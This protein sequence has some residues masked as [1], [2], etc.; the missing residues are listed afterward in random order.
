METTILAP[1]SGTVVAIN[2]GPPDAV[3]AGA[4]VLVLEAMKM[5]HEVVADSDGVLRSIEVAIGET[6]QEGQVL[7]VVG[8]SDADADGAADRAGRP[9]E[10]NASTADERREDLEAVCRR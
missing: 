9:D 10:R 2:H 6:V 7:A 3:H 1:F 5:E 4:P 8:I